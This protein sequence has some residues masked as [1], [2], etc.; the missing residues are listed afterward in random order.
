MLERLDVGSRCVSDYER[1]AGR[2]AIVWARREGTPS[3]ELQPRRV[4]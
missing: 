1:T 3:A 2:L 4:R